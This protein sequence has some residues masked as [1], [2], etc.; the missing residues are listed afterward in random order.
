VP[1]IT[2][3]EGGDSSAIVFDG[4]KKATAEGI[5]VLIVDTAGRLQNKKG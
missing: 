1:I 4:V 5:D 2:G 3:P